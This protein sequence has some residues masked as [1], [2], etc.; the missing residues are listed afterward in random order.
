MS[1]ENVEIVRRLIDA[2]NR[3][4]VDAAAEAA[5][6]DFEADLSNSRGPLTGVYRG[7]DQTREFLKSFLEAWASLQWDPEELIEL[8]D[9]RVISA[10][11]LR[12]SG[13]ASGAEVNARGAAIWKILDGK[14]AAVTLYQSKAEALE[15]AGLRE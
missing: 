7:R 6:E 8:K 12:M 4:D 5:N 3:G 11:R 15:A 1:Q 14:V 2:I 9:N 13:H 10:S